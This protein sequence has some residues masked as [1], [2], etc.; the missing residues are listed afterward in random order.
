MQDMTEDKITIDNVR[1][2]AKLSGFE[3]SDKQLEAYRDQ[4]QEILGYVE[5]LSDIDTK[6]V[7]PTYQVTGLTNVTREDE[8]ID[9]G[10]STEELL[11]NAPMQQDD[12][13]KVRRVI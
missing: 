1:E 6:E 9:Y 7:E 12:Q 11:K 2:V 4:F 5:R 8:I 13:I 10:V 3:F